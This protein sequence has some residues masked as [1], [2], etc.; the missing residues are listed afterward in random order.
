MFNQ[1]IFQS[2]EQKILKKS[3][4]NLDRW[5]QKISKSSYWKL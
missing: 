5:I 2:T 1:I 4:L 3:D